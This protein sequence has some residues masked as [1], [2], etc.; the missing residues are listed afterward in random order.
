MITKERLRKNLV[1]WLILSAAHWLAIIATIAAIEHQ[2][3][4]FAGSL[5][6]ASISSFV[7]AL[8]SFITLF[9]HRPVSTPIAIVL[10]AAIGSTTYLVTWLLWRNIEPDFRHAVPI[11]L[12][13][14]F[15]LPIVAGLLVGLS[16][17]AASVERAA[18]RE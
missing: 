7:F 17:Y 6:P 5:I 4:A 11:E 1:G 13:P 18:E 15:V 3:A 9:R 16:L 12:L 10:G 8:F 14:M 2:V